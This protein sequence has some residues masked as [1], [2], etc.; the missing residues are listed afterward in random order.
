VKIAIEAG[1]PLSLDVA[2][3]G[4]KSLTNRAL[5]AA[6]L[7]RGRS[8]LTN[9]SFSDDSRVLAQALNEVGVSVETREGEHA[10]LVDG[11]TIHPPSKP[12]LMGNAGTALRFFTS[13]ACTG[14]GTFVI[15]GDDRMRERPIGGLV[16]AL[17]TLGARISY[18]KRDG[19]P[20]LEIEAAGLSGGRTAVRGDTSSQFVSSLLLASPAARGAVEIQVD[21]E[22]AS[23]P[24]IEITLD[25]MRAMGVSVERE[26]YRRFRIP[27]GSRYQPGGLEIEADGASA[28]YFLAL[29]AA[30]G[31]R[32]TVRGIGS[33]SHQGEL[34]F[35]SI[36]ESMGCSVAWTPESILLK[37]GP[38]RGVDVDMNDCPDSVQTLA[39]VA[40]FAKG[41]TRVRNV[42]NL[43]VKETDRIAAIATECEKLGA[44]VDQHA[45]G[46]TLTPPSQVGAAEIETYRDHRM[47]MSFSV[48]AAARPG[49][50]LRDPECVSKSFPGYFELLESLG[51]RIHRL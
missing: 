51:L 9:A 39:A 37:G 18:G 45:D 50:I 16:D 8:R 15:D 19:C 4:S 21:G 20:P 48:A 29:A 6:A 32:A 47:A 7:A 12:L 44:R 38:L 30:T 43:R 24:Y 3:P 33:R 27:D 41:P 49:I 36:L 23:K 42:P 5:I 35:A 22:P 2:V 28:G 31:G 26:G 1:G 10:I 14:T 11:G 17:R 46:F 25:V 40:L 13:F 34:R